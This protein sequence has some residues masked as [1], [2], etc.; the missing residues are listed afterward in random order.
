MCILLHLMCVMVVA[1]ASGY[2]M[3]LTPVETVSSYMVESLALAPITIWQY[4]YEFSFIALGI[5]IGIPGGIF[6]TLTLHWCT[7]WPLWA[8]KLPFRIIHMTYVAMCG[9]AAL[10]CRSNKKDVHHAAGEADGSADGVKQPA[11]QYRQL[12]ATMIQARADELH[13]LTNHVLASLLMEFNINAGKP[14][15]ELMVFALSRC[16]IATGK[17]L[18]YMRHIA[19][20]QQLVIPV[21]AMASISSATEWITLH[22]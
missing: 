19:R 9:F 1:H 16:H 13:V 10:L 22:Q 6:L 18:K 20:R 5:A 8:A 15:K 7:C 2:S 4:G 14:N 12:D 21:Q 11:D 17:Q 3:A